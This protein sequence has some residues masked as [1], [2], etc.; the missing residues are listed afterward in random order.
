M[1]SERLRRN[2][3]LARSAIASTEASALDQR[4]EHRP[5]GHA[6]DVAH[7]ARQL[8]VGRFQELQ[9][10]VALGRLA[11]GE[12]AAVAQQLSHFPQRPGRHEA[13]RDQPVPDQIG[14][15]LGILHVRLAPRHVADVPSVADDQVEMSFQHGIDWP[16]VDA[17]ALHADM[18]HPRRR[19]PVPQGFEVARHRTER[20]H[21]L[22]RSI[23]G[24]ADQKT[25]NDRLLVHVQPT[26]P[27]N[28][29]PHH[30][31]L[32]SE[33]DRDAAGTSRHCH[34]C[35]P[36]PGATKNGTS[37]RRGPDCLSGSQTTAEISASTRSPVPRLG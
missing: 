20:A 24:R 25:R 34:T 6:E 15:P 8:D 1:R 2:W 36:F 13:L 32:P 3:P 7:H 35:S 28:N 19:E 18:R 5:A 22:G 21:L 4:P 9:Q 27:L 31:L 26:A 23:P 16:P 37:M 30:R 14:D 11:L 12:L 29:H 10:P 33:G 17:G